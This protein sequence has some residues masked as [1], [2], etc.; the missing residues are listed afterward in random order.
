MFKEKRF[1]ILLFCYTMTA[2]TALFQFLNPEYSIFDSGLIAIIL[3]TI[4]LEKDFYTLLFGSI[5]VVLILLSTFYPHGNLKPGEIIMQHLFSLITV[6]MTVILVL[7][8]K[9]LYRSI[10]SEQSRMNALFTFAT[11][12]I[13]LT[14]ETGQIILVN[15]AAEKLFKCQAREL[16]GQSI[17]SLIPERFRMGHE[18]Y[19][20]QF[21]D[22]PNNRTMGQGR[23][24]YAKTKDGTEFPVEVSLSHFKQGDH[25][26]VIAFVVDIT[27]R[28]RAELEMIAQKSKLEHITADVRK[29]NAELETKVGQRTQILREALHELEKS[30]R[31]LS[32]AL[33]KEKEL[34]EIKSRFVSMASHEFRTPLSTVL[35][36]ASLIGKYTK[37]EEQPNR[38]KHI[39]RIKDSVKHLNDLLGDFLSLGRLEEGRVKVE[40]ASFNVRDFVEELTDELKSIIKEGQEIHSFYEGESLFYSDTRLLKNILLNLLSNAIKF[41]SENS[42]IWVN[43]HTDGE[44]LDISI[45]DEGLGI[46]DE[47]QVHLFS[48]FFRGKNALNI[49]G[50][51]LGLHIVKGYVELLDGSIS[52]ESRLD[53]GTTVTVSLPA[54]MPPEDW[55]GIGSV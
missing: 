32:D 15:P 14:N 2:C 21:Y 39:K 16:D 18:K 49:E 10:K 19:R 11:E 36:S 17:D 31:E 1:G 35:S 5:S 9:K 24:L 42:S 25:F 44:S 20:H 45:K 12:G 40:P 34:S 50:T 43:F 46:S 8:A 52:L 30:K 22:H 38:D 55:G 37:S 27:E 33:N 51:G 4:L 53:Q 3:I 54:M 47:D 26:F 28:K 41:S 7:Y 23:D 29:L 13:I 48:S 6:I